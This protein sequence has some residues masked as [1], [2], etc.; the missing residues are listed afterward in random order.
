MQCL[1]NSDS[2]RGR[3]VDLKWPIRHVMMCD[4]KKLVHVPHSPFEFLSLED[5]FTLELETKLL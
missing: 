4:N 5:V 1:N 2:P 3:G